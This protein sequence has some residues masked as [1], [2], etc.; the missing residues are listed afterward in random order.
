MT[1]ATTVETSSLSPTKQQHLNAHSDHFLE[2]PEENGDNVTP[3][4]SSSLSALT[5]E[6]SSLSEVSHACLQ[7]N[8]ACS[9][10][11]N[12]VIHDGNLAH[13]WSEAWKRLLQCT[14]EHSNRQCRILAATTAGMTARSNYG[15]IRPVIQLYSQRESTPSRVEDEVLDVGLGLVNAALAEQDDGVA[16]AILGAVGHLVLTSNTR[17][18]RKKQ[19][20]F[21][22]RTHTN[23]LKSAVLGPCWKTS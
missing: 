14:R 4:E 11:N 1:M 15:R 8:Q 22:A 19:K 16:I 17:C 2:Y 5:N 21:Q 6:H 18:V 7:C 10:N 20:V 3:A 12:T 23:D 9:T 13:F